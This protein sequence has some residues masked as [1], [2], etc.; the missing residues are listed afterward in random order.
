MWLLL[1]LGA[2]VGGYEI[3]PRP[4]SCAVQTLPS[5]APDALSGIEIN[6]STYTVPWAD[7]RTVQMHMWYP[8][9]ATSGESARYLDMFVDDKSLVGAPYAEPLEGCRH[10]LLVYSHGSQAWAGSSSTVV[11][12][13]VN[14]GW[15][16]IAPDHTDNTLTQNVADKPRSFSLTRV[17]DVRHAIDWAESLP[18]DHA[19]A[20]RIDTSRVL[21]MGHSF[22]AQTSWLLS[23]PTFDTEAIAA[24]CAQEPQCTDEAIAAFA[25]SPGDARVVGVVPAAGSAN[26]SLVADEGWSTIAAPVLYMTGTADQDGT[27]AFERASEGDV[28]WIEIEGGCHESFTD[29]AVSCPDVDK[30]LGVEITARYATAFGTRTVLSSDD[31]DVAS[32]LDG[33]TVISDLVTLQTSR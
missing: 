29:T 14:A 17:E 8:T 3:E 4:E 31:A 18:I 26:T 6:P 30:A 13:F 16:V 28:T 10:P 25:E 15:V 20:G 7:E 12:Q 21:V 1:S 9:A 22:G 23:G 24:G 33:T 2:C 5:Y 32:V 19:L 11:R 27:E